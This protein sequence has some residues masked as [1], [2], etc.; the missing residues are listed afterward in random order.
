MPLAACGGDSDAPT[1]SASTG[2]GASLTVHAKDTL[3]F[4]RTSYSATA[5]KVDVVYVND[6]KVDH[7]L[8]IEGVGGF[9]LTIGGKD[10]GTVDLKAGEYTLFCDLPGHEAAGMK[11]SLTVS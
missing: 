1:T 11:A 9:K 4:D 7:T 8:R 6:G 2:A 5:G 10:E 3:K